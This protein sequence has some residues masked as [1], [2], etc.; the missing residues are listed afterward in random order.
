MQPFYRLIFKRILSVS[1]KNKWLWVLG[2]F[3]AIIGN[4]S[5]YESL[6][7]SFNNISEGRSALYTL[8]EYAESGIFGM[9][10]W[11]NFVS[12]WQADSAAFG[13][14]L[15]GLVV[16]LC[17]MAVIITLGVICQ[18]ALIRGVVDV[19]QGKKTTLKQSFKI[20]VERFWAIFEL[21]I[22]TKV[23]FFG[24]LMLLVYLVYLIPSISLA[25]N[26]FIY[27]VSFLIFIII[28]III[29]F[30]TIY[31]TAYIV[32][33]KQGVFEALNNAWKIFMK[34]IVLNIEMG[35]LLFLLNIIFAIVFMIALFVVLA[36]V[37][38][39][40]FLLAM[41][42]TKIGMMI[43]LLLGLIIFFI[44]VVLAGSWWTTFQLG[45]WAI[46]FEELVLKGGKSKI[47]RLL[48]HT[49]GKIKRK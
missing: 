43:A 49:K 4:G 46:L 40:Y 45:S 32:L 30:I 22:I 29:H 12:L 10:S 13:M 23:V 7:R 8:R 35:V 42:G 26:M 33:R 2:F 20:G 21:N 37:V 5:V 44:A 19:D 24:L 25:W 27:I 41:V 38:L 3:A 1:W 34:H 36:P 31:G 48:E 15:L 9:L 47:V 39:L 11:D 14:N 28:G 6:I 18:G 17:I 16:F